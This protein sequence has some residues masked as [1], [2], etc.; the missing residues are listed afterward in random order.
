MEENKIKWYNFETSFT[1]LARDLS[2]WLKG[3]KIKYELSDASVPGFPVYHFEIYTDGTG[4][5]AINRWLDEN[6]ITE[7]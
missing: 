5:D 2:A 6:T 1:S 4:V 3:K 7:C